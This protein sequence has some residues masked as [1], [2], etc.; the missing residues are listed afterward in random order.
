MGTYL[1]PVGQPSRGMPQSSGLTPRSTARSRLQRPRG[2]LRQLREE[3]GRTE[4]PASLQR[5]LQGRHVR[6]RQRFGQ[7]RPVA[8]LAL[9]RGVAEL[10]VFRRVDQRSVPAATAAV[11]E[12][13]ARRDVS[14][15]RSPLGDLAGRGLLNPAV[16]VPYAPF[17]AALAER[18]IVVKEEVLEE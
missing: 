7:Q 18:G 3:P 10:P 8:R 16:D 4:G 5:P 15:A 2:G 14:G 13:A 6:S 1:N 12:A 11:P 9:E 17:M